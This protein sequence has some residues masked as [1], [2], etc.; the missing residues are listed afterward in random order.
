MMKKRI[1]HLV[2]FGVIAMT[3][4]FVFFYPGTIPYSVEV[5][6]KILPWRDMTIS[7]GDD[8]IISVMVHD[9]LRGTQESR[10][11]NELERGD[12]MMWRLHRSVVPGTTV[13]EG[14]TICR[15][16][17]SEIERELVNLRGEL[18]IQRAALRL[19]ETGEKESVVEE[20][21]QF[22][23]SAHEFL[24]EQENITIRQQ[25]LYE[26]GFIPYQDYELAVSQLE[27]YR[28]EVQK[29]EAQLATVM[30]GVK[31]EEREF[32]LA[33]I[34]SLEHDISALTEK[35]RH[36]TIIAPFSGKVLDQYADSSAT[37]AIGDMS[38]LCVVM[39]V[40]LK[41][42]QF[43]K[44]NQTV[45]IRIDGYDETMRGTITNL[46]TVIRMVLDNQ[47]TVAIAVLDSPDWV[48]PV[49]IIADCKI[50]VEPVTVR[51]YFQRT[52]S[53]VL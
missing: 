26:A 32:I 18:D 8:G 23:A 10:F 42:N 34:T 17:S 30:T 24:N 5:I 38:Q 46:G 52:I 14:D 48:L 53:I 36:M 29:A 9:N 37:V 50:V 16:F 13:D 35:Q 27:I 25:A 45:E 4:Y 15:I 12:V 39:L 44:K 40:D 20:A 2:Q 41:H 47:V 11:L 49:G 19:V 51:E 28:I 21:R 43:V 3:V 7:A 6:G 33:S 22:V 1:P 31:R